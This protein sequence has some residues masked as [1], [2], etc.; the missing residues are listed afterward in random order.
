MDLHWSL[1]QE[2][3]YRVHPGALLARAMPGEAAGR[4]VLRLE[5]HDAAAH[6]LVHHVQHYFDRRLKWALDLRGL[7]GS[8]GFRWSLVAERL[9]D[10]GARG[11]AGLAL[12]HLA[13]LF[14][15]LRSEE[16]RAALPAA[17]WR[18]AAL[19]PLR[20]A[21]PLDLYRGTR[22]RLVQLWLAAAALERPRDLP[23][24]LRH[25]AVRDRRAGGPD[26]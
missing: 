20:S 23:G 21:H 13:R 15:E 24:Y 6:L 19:F 3:R 1:G 7:A 11:A 22:R 14:P 18:R 25:R 9:R 17:A 26:L 12:E 4:P 2:G 8:P 16:A 5:D 10:W